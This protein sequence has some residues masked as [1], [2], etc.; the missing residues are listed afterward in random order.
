MPRRSRNEEANLMETTIELH[1]SGRIRLRR[2]LLG[3]SQSD[4]AK[5]MGITF[6]QVQ[7]YEKGSNRV[8][9]GKLYR[10][11]DIL[12]VPLTYFFEGLTIEGR[13]LRDDASAFPSPILSRRE[14]DLVRAWK[15]A[16][17]AVADEILSLLRVMEPDQPFTV[18][19]AG[20]ITVVPLPEPEAVMSAG[21]K[22]AA[23]KQDMPPP[24]RR[25]PGRPPGRRHP[26]WDPTDIY[27]V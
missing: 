17:P 4:L 22:P 13:R 5:A 10:L 3:M 27:R 19:E 25:G 21:V 24:V 16:P 9:V 26:V 18:A 12:D 6:Q 8:S 14:L 20:K 1:V 15:A 7:K 2:G 23:E 11:A